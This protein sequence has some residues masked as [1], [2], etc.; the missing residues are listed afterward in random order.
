MGTGAE[1]AAPEIAASAKGAAE[2]GA[3]LTAAETAGTFAAADAGVGALTAAELGSAGAGL[4]AGIEGAAIGAGLSD[5]ALGA[6]GAGLG[7]GIEGAA[8]AAGPTD[9]ALGAAGAGLG[10]GIESAAGAGGGL[11]AAGDAAAATAAA[12]GMS[13]GAPMAGVEATGLGGVSGTGLSSAEAF[14]GA[15]LGAGGAVAAPPLG[16]GVDAAGAASGSGAFY[17]EELLA[18]IRAAQAASVPTEVS[19]GQKA[20]NAIT[21]NPLTAGALGLNVLGQMNAA[22]SGK[23]LAGQLKKQAQPVQEISDSLLAQYKAGTISPST[24]FDIQRWKDQSIAQTKNYYA[25]AGIPDSSAAQSAIANIEA[26]AVAME[27]QARQGL[28]T[29]G[30]NAAGVAAGPASAA[31]TAQAQQDQNLQQAS[32]SALNSLMLLQAMQSGGMA[33]GKK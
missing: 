21:N 20:L 15:E 19:M 30:L 3:A 11:A 28:L 22:K 24:S 10:S 26:K 4:G 7:S 33:P 6:A 16:T 17:E 12:A 27:D 13:S 2:A 29:Q 18:K 8:A 14:T 32:G 23:T 31:I 25:K 1:I 5:A 9:A